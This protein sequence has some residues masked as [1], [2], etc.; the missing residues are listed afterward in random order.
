[1]NK[2]TLMRG[3]SGQTKST[4]ARQI[5]LENEAKGIIT[6]IL[7]TDSVWQSDIYNMKDRFETESFFNAD[8][9]GLAHKVNQAKCAIALSRKIPYIIIDN[10]NLS[11]EN[12]ME[13]Y[14]KMALAAG[15]EVDVVE[16]RPAWFGDLEEHF[17]RNVHAVPR[18]V[19][20]K[21]LDRFNRLDFDEINRKIAAL[22]AEVV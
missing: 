17:K 12:E 4:V 9:L 10:T 20:K 1:M 19:L 5:A 21:Q 15:Y 18:E 22:R 2:L 7:S 8:S 11:W 14:V 6:A 13:P 3:I 16:P